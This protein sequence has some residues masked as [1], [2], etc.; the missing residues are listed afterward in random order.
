MFGKN[1]FTKIRPFFKNE[2]NSRKSSKKREENPWYLENLNR[3]GK[4][5]LT[6]SLKTFIFTDSVSFFKIGADKNEEGYIPRTYQEL[7]RKT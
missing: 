3:S 1:I 7:Y 2:E 5:Y 4:K 6:N